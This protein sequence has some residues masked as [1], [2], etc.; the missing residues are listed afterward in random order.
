VA[1]AF[2]KA[3]GILTAKQALL[4]RAAAR[5]LEKETLTESEL[6]ALIDERAK[7]AA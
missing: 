1:Q 3:V 2:Y 5:L 7:S 4:E 6:R